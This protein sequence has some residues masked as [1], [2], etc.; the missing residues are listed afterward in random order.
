MLKAKR[1]ICSQCLRAMGYPALAVGPDTSPF[2]ALGA[3]IRQRLYELVPARCDWCSQ[4]TFR[5]MS[6]KA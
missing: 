5:A 4:L 3:G 2:V 6:R 1:T